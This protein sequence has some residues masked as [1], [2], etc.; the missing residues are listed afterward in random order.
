MRLARACY[1]LLALGLAQAHTDPPE[2]LI[3]ITVGGV[4][5][6]AVF[7]DSKGNHVRDLQ[8]E[9]FTILQDGEPKP[10]T[11]FAYV[12]TRSNPTPGEPF[13]LGPRPTELDRSRA[14]RTIA[15]VVD[16]LRMSFYGVNR[17]RN[18]LHCDA[19]STNGLA[20]TTSFRSQGPP[21]A[22]A[23]CGASRSTNAGSTRRWT[24]FGGARSGGTN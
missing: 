18:R 17:T 1:C 16:D 9:D 19:S 22:L 6:D 15:V 21:Q 13:R 7:T 2:P 5:V 10:V 23:R 20:R 11:N 12:D 24:I 14:C 4:Q 3:K 8:P